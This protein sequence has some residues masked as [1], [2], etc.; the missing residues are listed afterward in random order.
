MRSLD[1]GR[2][3]I[4]EGTRY[5]GEYKSSLGRGQN[6][7]LV[8]WSWI[9]RSDGLSVEIASPGADRRAGLTGKIDTISG[10]RFGSAIMLSVMGG[11]AEYA[12]HL[13]IPPAPVQF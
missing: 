13:A 8:A 7:I 4:P 12:P 11:A 2:I 3:L 10:E 5:V 6:R 9:I 1:G